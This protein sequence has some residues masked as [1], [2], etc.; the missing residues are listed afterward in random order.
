MADLKISQ[1]TALGASPADGD[2]I[3]I[4]DVSDTTMAASGTTKKLASIY[5]ARSDGANKL[6]TGSGRELTVPATGTTAL[7]TSSTWV[8]AVSGTGSAPTV[9]YS[10]LRYG[11]YM[12]IGDLVF[13]SFVVE[14]TAFSGG[15]GN[16][17]ITLPFTSANL[18]GGAATTVVSA[19]LDYA[20]SKTF[21][22][23][24]VDPNTDVLY[25]LEQQDNTAP[26]VMPI[27]AWGAAS[28]V[29][30]SI[31]YRAAP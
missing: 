9:T 23:A 30:G 5:V 20:A 19:K 14:T 8:P 18:T 3:P 26:S 2:L 17:V 4:V 13:A 6:I 22:V 11:Y 24:N 7:V 16:L 31:V 25:F 15:S 12:R 27:T 21:V 1:L 28:Y 29:Q 10:A